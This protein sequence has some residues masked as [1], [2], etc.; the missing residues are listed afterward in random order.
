MIRYK[1]VDLGLYIGDINR[2]LF[3]V[4]LGTEFS[5][6]PH[7]EIG[8]TYRSTFNENT[9]NDYSGKVQNRYAKFVSNCEQIDWTPV[10]LFLE[11]FER[12]REHNAQI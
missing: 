10:I 11:Y 2:R 9:L 1:L 8:T 6:P 7:V 5:I 3:L 12:K 4:A